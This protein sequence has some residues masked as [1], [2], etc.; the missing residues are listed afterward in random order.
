MSRHPAQAYLHEDIK[1][2]QHEIITP[3][4]LYDS[5]KSINNWDF[6]KPANP[7][8]GLSYQVHQLSWVETDSKTKKIQKR[9]RKKEETST[10]KNK[11]RI[12]EEEESSRRKKEKE[13]FK[14]GGEKG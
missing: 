7:S 6:L 8:R 12:R 10:R 3:S 13:L 9:C 11:K 2:R 1:A 5:S 14:K 4:Q